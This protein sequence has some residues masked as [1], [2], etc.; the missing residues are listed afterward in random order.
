MFF[1]DNRLCRN[2]TKLDLEAI[3]NPARF[4]N[5]PAIGTIQSYQ[6]SWTKYIQHIGDWRPLTREERISHYPP[7]MIPSCPFCDLVF[8]IGFNLVRYPKT[9]KEKVIL[10]IPAHL[11]YNF[12]VLGNQTSREGLSTSTS[13]FLLVMNPSDYNRASAQYYGNTAT[14]G[15]L[16]A[17]I[18]F[19]HREAPG[20]LV[21][22]AS[23]AVLEPPHSL[24]D[25]PMQGRVLREEGI[26]YGLVRSWIHLCEHHHDTCRTSP[27]WQTLPHFKLIDCES[28]RIIN[29]DPGKRYRYVALS[30]VWGVA[31]P[32]Q[33]TY[34]CLP[35]NLPPV[36]QDAMG[37]TTK[38]GFRYLWIDRYC[39]WQ[40]DATHKMSQV[41]RM[42]QIYG[43]AE[44]T[45]IAIGAKDPSYGLPGLSLGRTQ[46][47]PTTKTIGRQKIVT[48]FSHQWQLDQI[49]RSKWATRGWTFQETCLSRRRL[50]FSNYEVSFECHDMMCFEH[51]T[52][53]LAVQ[54]NLEHHERPEWTLLNTPDGVWAILQ[55]YCDRQLTY[56]SDRLAAVSGVLK[57]WSRVNTGCFSYWG[58]PVVASGWPV[59]DATASKRAFLAGL[60]WEVRP[61]GTNF[62]RLTGFPSW[63]WVSQNGRTLFGHQGY[64]HLR[65]PNLVEVTKSFD[66]EV[67]VET[68]RGQVVEWTEFHE[69]GGLDLLTS[70]CTRYLHIEC[71]SFQTGSLCYRRIKRSSGAAHDDLFYIPTTLRPADGKGE[72]VLK[73]TPDFGYEDTFA[74]REFTAMCFSPL[75]DTTSAVVI[76]SIPGLNV[77][78]GLLAF[79]RVED[80]GSHESQIPENLPFSGLP[81]AKQRR[82]FRLG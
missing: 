54:G 69:A 11:L 77:R 22:I 43:D 57:K 47:A 13:V 35:D 56:S 28:R 14:G 61:E 49:S 6:T 10:A 8:S 53:P 70:Q 79:T 55:K 63:S 9:E 60:E 37:A 34:P 39:I 51:L 64:F 50:Y 1:S 81:F 71:W 20:S 73:F 38:L 58:I 66:A 23:T 76:N 4:H 32:D 21:S 48:K 19:A 7:G 44:L 40:D 16:T 46:H 72:L 42:D 80:L 2:C 41:E 25:C 67:W 15:G 68:P 5:L 65:P 74:G 17:W 3:F 62:A 29:A 82:R 59:A 27:D 24:L 30:Y 18:R 52:R 31:P 12:A 45:I 78:V 75:E 36:I 33:Y 26:D